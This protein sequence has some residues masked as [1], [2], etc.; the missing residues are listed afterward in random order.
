[1]HPVLLFANQLDSVSMFLLA[2]I[3]GG[4]WYLLWLP[5]QVMVTPRRR[6]IHWLGVLILGLI[7]SPLCSYI[8]TRFI[9]RR[10]E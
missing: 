7:L 3:I 1:M 4:I 6:R 2:I 10:G 5:Y 8:I 9:G